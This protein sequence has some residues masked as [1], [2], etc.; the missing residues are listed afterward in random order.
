MEFQRGKA[1]VK[2][3]M[4]LRSMMRKLTLDGPPAHE[5]ARS[6]KATIEKLGSSACAS[7]AR[8]RMVWRGLNYNS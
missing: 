1:K 7:K 5:V 6:A 3:K 2:D 4:P 8:R